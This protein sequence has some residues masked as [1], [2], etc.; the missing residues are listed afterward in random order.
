MKKNSY[1]VFALVLAAVLLA[2]CGNAGKG[3]DTESQQDSQLETESGTEIVMEA[4]T[5][6][7]PEPVVTTVTVSAAGDCSL[8]ALQIHGYSGSFHDFYDTYGEAYFFENFKEIFEADDLTLVNLEGVLTTST[9]RVEKRFNIKGKPEY[10]GIMTSSSIEA[11]SLGNNHTSD[12]GPESLEDTK[13]AL[14][15]AGILY[16]YNDIISYYTTEDG[17][18][19]AMVSTSVTASGS[20][21][22]KYVLNGVT[23][24]RNQ[25]ADIVI[26]CCHWGIETE[27]YPT[28][29]QQSLGHQLIDAGAD[30][31]IGNHPHVLQ[32][33]EEY[34]GKIICYSLGNFSF[35]GN[36]NPSDKNT[37]VYQQTFTFVDGVLQT[38]ITAKII[39]SRISGHDGYNDF[40]PKV[41]TGEQA[42]NII[43]KMNTYSEP[44]S[45]VYFDEQGN[46]LIK[47]AE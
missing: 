36:R 23:E 6:S 8:G 5:E 2:G 26:A 25:G 31:V 11:V 24:A 30:L 21:N 43:S 32:G 41:A 17:I 28:E 10:T 39:P 4:E 22:Q 3:S 12:Y 14:D 19:V 37:A 29:Y 44:Y 47:E 38:D 33:I 34:N 9:N 7:E 35:G 27:H 16:A 18:V 13:N 15:E 1:K 45:G 20:T 46:L 42:A 40:Q